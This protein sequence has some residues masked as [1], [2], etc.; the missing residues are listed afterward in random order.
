M[1]Q[2]IGRRADFFFFSPD[3]QNYWDKNSKEEAQYCFSKF[4][5]QR[6]FSW[7]QRGGD[8]LHFL[9]GFICFIMLWNRLG[10]LIEAIMAP[11]ME[12]GNKQEGGGNFF[13]FHICLQCKGENEHKVECG[14]MGGW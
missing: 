6:S 2:L 7:K 4:W 12:H 10:V 9:T 5:S 14:G 8:Y 1:D 3:Q 13:C 11:L